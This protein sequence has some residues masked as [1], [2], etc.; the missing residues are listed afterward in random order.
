MSKWVGALQPWWPIFEHEEH[1]NERMEGFTDGY[2]DQS[3]A[4]SAP[5]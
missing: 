2:G 3:L 4:E 1:E 5:A